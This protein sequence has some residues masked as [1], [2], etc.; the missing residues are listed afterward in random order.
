L[1]PALAENESQEMV[2][3]FYFDDKPGVLG[4]KKIGNSPISRFDES[5]ELSGSG[6]INLNYDK[7]D[8][9]LDFPTYQ[10]FENNNKSI[11]DV[12]KLTTNALDAIDESAFEDFLAELKRIADKEKPKDRKSTRL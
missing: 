3:G 6:I 9:L 8:S 5:I 12:T 11:S 4:C 10:D 2:F 7:R 1:R